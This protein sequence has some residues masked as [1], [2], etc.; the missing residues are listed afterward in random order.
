MNKYHFSLYQQL[1]SSLDRLFVEV[2]RSHT[3]RHIHKHKTHTHSVGL[4]ST[5]DQFVAVAATYTTPKQNKR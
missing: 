1:N 5:S 2:S 3:I 4:L